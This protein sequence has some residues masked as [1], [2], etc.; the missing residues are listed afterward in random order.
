[1]PLYYNKKMVEEK[2][3][4]DYEN[5]EKRENRILELEKLIV[6]NDK[7][8]QEIGQIQIESNTSADENDL[9]QNLEKV[10]I[11]YMFSFLIIDF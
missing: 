5:L 3:F 1:M 10:I 2:Y 4:L 7:K 6:E 8:I 11:F 9:I